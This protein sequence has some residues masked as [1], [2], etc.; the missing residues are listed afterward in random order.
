MRVR[1]PTREEAKPRRPKSRP[2]AV[3]TLGDLALQTSWVWLYCEA[4][5]CRHKAPL[6]LA[7]P[8]ERYGG[9]M[10]SSVLRDRTRCTRCG[11]FGAT[12]R[13]PSW[14]GAGIG[15]APFPVTSNE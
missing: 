14:I 7:A 3:P 5:G 10:T 9:S 6:N 1:E 13:L 2:G 8:I 15:M 11:T 4:L 12:L